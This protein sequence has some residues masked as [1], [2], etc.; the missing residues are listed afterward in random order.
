MYV[1]GG[2]LAESPLV[3]DL[4]RKRCSLPSYTPGSMLARASRLSTAH[5]ETGVG[6]LG[7][8]VCL[9]QWIRRRVTASEVE[10]RGRF[11]GVRGGREGTGCARFS[12]G[13]GCDGEKNERQKP[14]LAVARWAQTSDCSYMYLGEGAC[15][16]RFFRCGG[17]EA[18]VVTGRG[19]GL[20]LR[21]AAGN[22]WQKYTWTQFFAGARTVLLLLYHL[23]AS[24]SLLLVTTTG[25]SLRF[26]LLSLL[27]L[28]AV[29]C[30][31]CTN[32]DLMHSFCLLCCIPSGNYS[33]SRASFSRARRELILMHTLCLLLSAGYIRYSLPRSE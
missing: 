31:K 30:T 5:A 32:S 28:F 27:F 3:A 1:A 4:A 11:R 10:W 8:R 22:N 25:S 15:R 9:I 29:R 14:D 26:I 24:L 21:S 6:F 23:F 12:S 2:S 33:F 18:V 13:A 20:L 16:D 19:G 7:F 17:D